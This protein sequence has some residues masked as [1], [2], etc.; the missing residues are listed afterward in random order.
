MVYY[1]HPTGT[2][3]PLASLAKDSGYRIDSLCAMLDVSPRSLRR[4]FSSSLG[5]CPKK[6]LKSERMVCAR[7]LLRG[8]LSVKEVSEELGFGAQKDFHR[9]FREFYQIAPTEFRSQESERLMDR[10]GLNN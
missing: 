2:W 1:I 5:I 9:E 8:G 3:I 7:N 4:Q 6:Y 10:F